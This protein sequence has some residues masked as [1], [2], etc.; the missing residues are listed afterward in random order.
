[1]R[2]TEA[3]HFLMQSAIPRPLLHWENGWMHLESEAGVLS[4]G[5]DLA[6]C[7]LHWSYE[8]RQYK[9]CKSP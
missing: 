4:K 5:A 2:Y 8:K 1:M 7:S 3:L 6:E 9:I